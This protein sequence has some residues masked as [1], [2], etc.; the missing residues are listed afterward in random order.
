MELKD[1]VRL[2]PNEIRRDNGL[3]QLFV[4][5]YE[6]AFSLTPKCIGCSFK[7]NFKKLKRYASEKNIKFDKKIKIMKANTFQLKSQYK[8]KILTFKKEG[9]T[10]RKYGHAIDEDFAISLVNDG[11]R[12]LFVK[13]P[14]LKVKDKDVEN[15]LI[16]II[17]ATDAL[18]TD[19]ETND[20][21]SLS[22][23]KELLPLYEKIKDKTGL[24]AKSYKK[25][26]IISFLK[27]HE[28]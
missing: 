21:S 28:G 23:H 18:T 24:E 20:Y 3:M 17:D 5:F 2:N 12:D 1:F 15:D 26:D 11:K 22:Y 16:S 13:L 27:Q 25:V 10:Y 6:A 8:L 19:N 9:I 14:D 4:N 7:G